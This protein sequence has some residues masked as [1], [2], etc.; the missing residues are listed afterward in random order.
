[1]PL[2]F[3]V[4]LT[5]YG[6]ANLYVFTRMF[7][8]IEHFPIWTKVIVIALFI[9]GA[10]SY[11]VAKTVFS[12]ID[13]LIYD[14]FLS[15]GSIW[16]AVL[17]YSFFTCLLIDLYRLLRYLL[18]TVNS[19][20]HLPIFA[21]SVVVVAAVC[22]IA[23]IIGYGI[24]NAKSLQVKK[25]NLDLRT[26]IAQNKQM[27]VMYF[28]DSHFSAINDGELL[29]KI[30]REIEKEKPDLILMGGDIVDDHPVHLHR[31]AIDKKLQQI[32]APLGVFTCPGNHESINGKAASFAYLTQNGISVLSDSVVHLPN[33]VYLAGRADYGQEHNPME[34]RKNLA[35]LLKDR[36]MA[37]PVI[38]LDH[39]PFHLEQAEQNKVSLQLSGH[40][41]HGQ[42]FPFNF[43]TERVYEKSWGY[44]KKSN[45]HYY[46][47][48]GIG[49]WGPPLKIGNDSE[50][51]VF[52][53]TW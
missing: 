49:T 29:T 18:I 5:V 46:I 20:V 28:S 17:M 22:L 10:S 26:G 16:F 24:I 36:D 42:M 13:S 14:V 30:L 43:I 25:M 31:H 51:L 3:I 27:K 11:I 52:T 19:S 1:M 32:K 37:A 40:T 33:G 7:S 35:T 21:P 8:A 2:F 48:S 34:G 4:F 45:T 12:K 39:Q 41:H 6:L 38:L 53:I 44:L 50:L 47:S 15:I 9:T 23:M